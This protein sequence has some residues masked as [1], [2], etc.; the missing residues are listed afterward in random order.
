MHDDLTRQYEA[1][2]PLLD[3]LA[4]N[5]QQ[6][7][8]RHFDAFPHIDR[9]SFRTKRP[10]SF[11]KKALEERP[12][13]PYTEPLIEVEDQVAG[14]I[15]VLFTSDV[16]RVLEHVNKIL[17]PVE[18]V[19]RRP[20]DYNV[21]DYESYH[22]IYSV[23]LTAKPPGW[24]DRDDLPRTFELQIRTLFQHAYAESQHDLGY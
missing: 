1:R 14:R 8:S 15:I 7:L 6:E 5:V 3:A 13:P 24:D 10:R 4:T 17:S 19:D 11:A 12:G 23:P 2:I 22:G 18:M 9:L 20:A 16:L 21:F